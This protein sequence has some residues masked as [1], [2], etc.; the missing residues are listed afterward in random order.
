MAPAKLVVITGGGSRQSDPALLSDR[1]RD[2]TLEELAALGREA[3]HIS[4][5]LGQ[6]T[7][8]IRRYRSQ[9]LPSPALAQVLE[10]LRS[11]SGIIVNTPIFNSTYSQ[12]FKLFWD[13]FSEGDL[14]K[15]P[16]LLAAVGATSSHALVLDHAIRP[17]LGHLGA[18]ILPHSVFALAEDLSGQSPSAAAVSDRINKASTLLAARMAAQ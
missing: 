15:T 14:G 3:V 13:S 5:H 17:L 4:R 9:G 8:D 18:A 1:I 2:R 16:T 7:F 12:V 10:D 6:Y 11:A